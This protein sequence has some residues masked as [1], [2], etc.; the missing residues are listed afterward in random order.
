MEVFSHLRRWRHN[1]LGREPSRASLGRL[2]H[3]LEQ[4]TAVALVELSRAIGTESWDAAIRH[5]VKLDAELLEVERVNFWQLHEETASILCDAGYVA[6]LRTFEHGATLSER[7]LPEYFTAMREGRVIDMPDVQTD[8]RCTGLREYCASRRIAS[9]LDVPVWVEGGLAGVLC[10]EHVGPIR[11]WG[12]HEKD[13]VTSVSQIVSSALAARAHAEAEAS[14]QRAIFLDTVSCEISSLDS[15]EVAE[16]AVSLC[17]PKLAD[18]AVVWSE[19]DQGVGLECRA[20]KHVDPA[21]DAIVRAKLLARR[22]WRPQQSGLAALAML[23]RQSMLIPDLSAPLLERYGFDPHTARAFIALD[24]RT[25][26]SVPLLAGGRTVGALILFMAD[27]RYGTDD[28]SLADAVGSRLAAALTNAHLYE[29]ARDAIRTRDE[30]INARDELLVL[31]AHEL[32]TP[33]TALQL[34]ADQ[35]MQH[36]RRARDGAEAARSEKIA[37][38]ARRFGALVEHILEAMRIRAEGVTLSLARTD[39]AESVRHCVAC[40]ASRAQAAGS[41][42]TASCPPELVG[43]FDP[44]RIATVIDALIDNAIKFGRGRPIEVTLTVDGPRAVLSVRDEGMGF[45]PDRLSGL[46]DAFGRGVPKEHYGG[47]GLGLY[48]AKAIVEAHGG[49]IAATSRPD[50]GATFVVRL[51]LGG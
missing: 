27:R 33:L 43:N 22:K 12:T 36:A 10:H 29:V 31:A 26:L 48:I 6:S 9:M 46:F 14:R 19:S 44:A 21:K 13:F 41:V 18:L 4:G 15:R 20:A 3:S 8:P 34:M 30:A 42:I 38:Q 5:I 45:S 23:Q 11:R 28:E 37:L 16:R 32:R 25:S 35:V 47:L 51:P 50:E 39:L 1:R 2:P 7:Q 17:V 24:L 49:S 40:V